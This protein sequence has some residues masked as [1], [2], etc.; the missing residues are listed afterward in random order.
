MFVTRTL[1]KL[2][3]IPKAIYTILLCF[4]TF[5]C[6]AQDFTISGTIKDDGNLSIPYANIVVLQAQD[7][8]VV[9]GTSSDDNGQ[10]TIS[11]VV[12]G[13]YILKTSFIGFEDHFLPLNISQDVSNVLIVLKEEAE[14]LS[15]VE[16]VVKKPTFKREADRLIFNVENT[17]LSEGNMIE[18]LRSTPGVLVLDNSISVKNS[19]PTIYINDR[20]VHLT[21]EE[22]VELLKGTPASNIKSVEVITNPPARYDADS[23]NIINIV[24]SKNLIT[25]YRGSIFS[26]ITQGVF[27]RSNMGISQ[28]F[29]SSK[30]SVYANYSYNDEKIDRVNR[31]QIEYFDV[32]G[33]PDQTW[34]TK[35]D[36]NYW[37]ETHNVNAN[38]DYDFDEHNQMSFSTNM[39]FL[40]YYKY[41]TRGQTFIS[42]AEQGEI[43]RFNSIN[44]SRDKKK[45]LGFN[46]DYVHT[47][48][49]DNA[50]LS[51]NAHTTIYDYRRKQ[52]V[53]SDYFLADDSFLE[54]N[55][56]RTRSDQATNIY[57]TQLDYALPIGETAKL[58]AGL[59]YSNVQTESM[60]IQRDIEGNQEIID[61]TNTD[62]FEYD[63]NVFAA[64]LGFNKE[65]EKWDVTL[66][67]RAEQTNIEGE[68]ML[69]NEK[70]TQDYLE[71][72]PNASIMFT[73]SDNLSLHS[74]Y[75]RRIQRPNYND[76]NPFQFFLNDNTLVTG[77]PA[78]Q[79]V[80]M[81]HFT[82]GA[83]FNDTYT[84]EVYYIR[85]Q[86]NISE[87]PLQD[88]ATNI[89]SYT[90]INLDE[91]HDF[92]IDF[93]AY[94]NIT[95]RW[96]TSFVT[97]VYRVED[98]IRINNNNIDL[99]QWANYSE[100]SNSLS[101]LED[102][103][104]SMDFTLI[105]SSRNL[106]GL[107]RIER[108]QLFSD[109]SIRKTMLKGKGAVS[110]AVSNL[111][112]AQ[113]YYLRTKFVNQN[114]LLFT[115]LD[116]RY[117]RLGFRYR[118]GN[119]KLSTNQKDITKNERDRLEDN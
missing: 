56:F 32:N 69:S 19:S 98:R 94:F 54:N 112:N 71:F 18:V 78:L 31:E 21:M 13:N 115:N 24:M 34:L 101:F 25:G 109:L 63:E 86:D 103:S 30:L 38:L 20:K 27:P 104:L 110:L 113:H 2:F 29:K 73:A 17:S 33:N 74:T 53:N 72:F 70:N 59:K 87:V 42:P 107:Q 96:T 75:N 7:S 114:S 119:T 52:R 10:F 81:D 4:C 91:T 89:I 105:F 35:L 118:F 55:I 67:V 5:F 80:F 15:E 39:V 8:T 51:F 48:K 77:N 97:S 111:F 83:T 37:S 43:A 46:L 106:Q 82:L 95:D 57:T 50:T 47:F 76:L 102:N 26:N 22:V 68:S 41:L 12:A 93:L 88:N 28:F 49:K 65:W 108:A 92:G 100:L 3:L 84:L 23:G 61:P 6:F 117:V 16:I 116:D 44:L 90:P 79:P 62:A 11:S 1:K 99:N 60:I 66:G 9:T 58:E 64:Y 36:R 14:A 85:S 45:N 40:P